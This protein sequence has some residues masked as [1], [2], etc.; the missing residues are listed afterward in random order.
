MAVR[1]V[2]PSNTP[3]DGMLIRECPGRNRVDPWGPGACYNNGGLIDCVELLI[4]PAVRVE[5]L[6]VK[7]DWQSGVIEAEVNV[8]ERDRA[9][10]PGQCRARAWCRRPAA[11]CST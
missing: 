8:P 11:R 3:I 9:A 1:V 4:A 2:N 6:Y 5:S 10:G 7:P